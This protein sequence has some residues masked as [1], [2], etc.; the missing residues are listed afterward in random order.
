MS[1]VREGGE[2]MSVVGGRE[3]EVCGEERGMNMRSVVRG[4]E[5]EER[6]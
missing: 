2:K 1:N 5:D 4:R 3:D 6:R